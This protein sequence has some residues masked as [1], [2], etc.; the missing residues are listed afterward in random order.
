MYWCKSMVWFQV[1]LVLVILCHKFNRR[2]LIQI[3][4]CSKCSCQ[5]INLNKIFTTHIFSSQW[6]FC[7]IFQSVDSVLLCISWLTGKFLKKKAILGIPCVP[8]NPGWVLALLSRSF[9][10]LLVGPAH[11][12]EW[13]VWLC[14]FVSYFILIQTESIHSGWYTRDFFSFT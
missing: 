13:L 8:L 9:E 2:C 1:G 4:S 11:T 6:I 10:Y 12:N 7:W 14:L 3:T 5:N